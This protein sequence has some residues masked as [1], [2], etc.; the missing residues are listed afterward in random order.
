MRGKPL[1][2]ALSLLG[3]APWTAAQWVTTDPT[4]YTYF[5]EQI[6]QAAETLKSAQ[7]T[8]DGIKG[9]HN[10]VT[11]IYNRAKGVVGDL[12]KAESVWRDVDGVLTRRGAGQGM[13]RGDGGFVDID[14][15]ING[16]YGDPRTRG[17]QGA[18]GRHE[19]QQQAL[20][21]VIVDSEKLLAGVADRLAKVGELAGQIDTTQNIKDSA[22]L[23]NRIAIEILKTLVDMLA[24]AAKSHQAQ[25]LFNYSG[26]TDAGTQERQ[27]V[28][29][30]ANR[31]MKSVEEVWGKS[32][33]Y[34]NGFPRLGGL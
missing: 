22:D 14:K 12:K 30:D 34:G 24:I 6:K 7:Q 11:G 31:S 4:S 5:V 15:V 19:V 33:K 21:G 32:S 17:M 28:L 10:Q 16:T 25:S 27:R 8:V 9:V 1:F 26:V 13:P 20:K 29:N 23:G 2:L 3:F 18:D